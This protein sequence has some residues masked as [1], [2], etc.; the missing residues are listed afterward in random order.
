MRKGAFTNDEDFVIMVGERL[1]GH[2]WAR[3]VDFMPYRTANQIH[4][5]YNTFLKANFAT[6]TTEENQRLLECVKKHGTKNWTKIAQ[7]VSGSKTRT[8]C[9]NRFNSIYRKYLKNPDDFN[10]AKVKNSDL[11]SRRQDE[12]HAKLDE[13]LERFL[14]A[15]QAERMKEDAQGVSRSSYHVTPSGARVAREDL[16][17]FLFLLKEKLPSESTQSAYI[18]EC[19]GHGRAA[20]KRRRKFTDAEIGSLSV[21]ATTGSGSWRLPFLT[22]RKNARTGKMETV[23]AVR[24]GPG[25]PAVNR[26]TE[27]SKKSRRLDRILMHY[28]RPAWVGIGKRKRGSK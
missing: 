12:L 28:F 20:T 23:A 21:R 13:Q 25:R 17:E 9:R 15:Q 8:Q 10:L 24:K 2:D 5:R 1:F 4:S 22:V 19:G 14:S 3:I 16:Y 26:N 6:W 27:L 7:E 11:Q 18:D